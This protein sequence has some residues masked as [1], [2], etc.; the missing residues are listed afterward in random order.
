VH[1][2]NPITASTIA[3]TAIRPRCRKCLIEHAW[4]GRE[5]H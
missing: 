4:A 5:Q 2:A 3:E 1:P